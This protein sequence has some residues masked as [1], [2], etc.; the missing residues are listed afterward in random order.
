MMIN[1]YSK[2]FFQAESLT[3]RI[4]TVAFS[5]L[6]AVLFCCPLITQ[7]QLDLTY[8]KP[9]KEILDMV[10]TPLPPSVLINDDATLMV[11]IARDQFRS[12]AE[13]SEPE[14][15]LGGL[16]I[17]P[18]TNIGSRTRFYNQVT[19]QKVG[20]K[21]TM[22]IEGLPE[23][24]RAANLS[25]SPDQS[26]VAFT[27]TTSK[28]VELWMADLDTRQ[29]SKLTEDVLNANIGS[30]Y[31]W[32]PDGSGFIVKFLPEDRQALIDKTSTI[33]TGPRIS[34]NEAGVKAQNRTYQDLLKDKADEANFE[35]LAK[36]TLYKVDLEGNKSMWKETGMYRYVRFSPNGEYV[37]IN[38]IKKPFS[39]LVP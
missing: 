12:I 31:T 9:A 17:N 24:Y 7:A 15:R 3:R 4:K 20:E 6:M 23:T 37:M 38:T 28:G 29:A 10:D 32:L 35:Q 36:S 27:N 39:Y 16:R 34:V 11:L 30:P 33:P 18:V 21:K 26:K 13:L 19:L 2:S 22:E 1:S 5:V 8:Q 25:W 14:L